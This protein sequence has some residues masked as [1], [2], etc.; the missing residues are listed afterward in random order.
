M[1]SAPALL[2][3][4]GWTE[5]ELDEVLY[6]WDKSTSPVIEYKHKVSRPLSIDNTTSNANENANVLPPTI[7]PTKNSPNDKTENTN[8]NTTSTDNEEEELVAKVTK[9]EYLDISIEGDD[10]HIFKFYAY[11]CPHCQHFKPTYVQ[12]AKE[13]V[14]RSINVNVFFSCCVV[15]IK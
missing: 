9:P 15:Y 13:V 6:H 7:S 4:P 14:K 1:T 3:F 2:L 10:V 5:D 8:N 12:I 11:W